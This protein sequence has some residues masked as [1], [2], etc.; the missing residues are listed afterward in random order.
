MVEQTLAGLKEMRLSAMAQEH[1]RQL[2]VAETLELTFDERLSMMCAAEQAK[3]A[4]SRLKRLVRSATLADRCAS[5]EEIRYSEGRNISK[6]AIARLSGLSWVRQASNI[7]FTGATGTGKSWIASA[8]G[9]YACLHGH[10]TKMVRLPRLDAELHYAR[11]ESAYL[12]LLDRLCRVE[13]LIIDDFGLD[14]LDTRLGRDLL[15][16]A[17]ARYRKRPTV[18]TAQVP[19]AGWHGLFDDKTIADAFLDRVVHNSYRLEL[20][21]PSL[22]GEARIAGTAKEKY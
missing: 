17:D 5:L 19:V 15:E 3:R 8:W 13:V 22:R 10:S 9:K 1:S 18:L 2:E 4:D 20:K 21:G 6:E 14:R 16:I 11:N 7:I 12:K